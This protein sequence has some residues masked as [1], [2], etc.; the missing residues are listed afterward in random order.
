MLR[1]T[2][3]L[4]YHAH[5]LPS[6]LAITHICSRITG[7]H[8]A[9][10]IMRIAVLAVI[11]AI[12]TASPIPVG[13]SHPSPISSPFRP[14]PP[15]CPLPHQPLA[16]SASASPVPILLPHSP[17][18]LALVGG[19]H[20][21]LESLGDVEG[22][23]RP[24]PPTPPEATHPHYPSSTGPIPVSHLTPPPPLPPPPTSPTPPHTAP[25]RSPRP[26]P[27]PRPPA[28]GPRHPRCQAPRLPLPRDPARRA[29]HRSTLRPAR[30][31]AP[32][33]PFRGD[34]GRAS[35]G[36]GGARQRGDRALSL[37][38][39]QGVCVYQQ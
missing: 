13:E 29:P 10:H 26:L 19:G 32:P 15:S 30:P 14:L 33:A 7:V 37:C 5:R 23:E 28:R 18:P 25:P 3:P 20:V 34:V 21:A 4:T 9:Q 11:A 35:R 12:A 27:P 36:R 6:L 17:Y 39:E 8:P 38:A 22:A 1:S 2:H 31:A 24:A 16:P